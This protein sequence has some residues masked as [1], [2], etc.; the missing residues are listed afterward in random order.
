MGLSYIAVNYNIQF[1]EA[2]RLLDR[3]EESRREVEIHTNKLNELEEALNMLDRSIV[4]R[5]RE[6]FEK[7]G[8]EQF[9]P[10]PTKFSCETVH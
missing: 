10:D 9:R 5:Y 7:R 3:Y 4:P 2:Q 1:S 6:M 8:G